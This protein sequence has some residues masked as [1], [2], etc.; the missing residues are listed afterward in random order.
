[1]TMTMTQTAE[2]YSRLT[3]R[4]ADLV[5]GRD[6]RIASFEGAAEKMGLR[7]AQANDVRAE[8]LLA[9]AYGRPIEPPTLAYVRRAI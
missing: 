6:T 3:F 9:I 1:M 4:G 5:L 2:I 8:A 7:S